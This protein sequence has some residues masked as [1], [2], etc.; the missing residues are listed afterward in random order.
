M[1]SRTVL[2]GVCA[3]EGI[4]EGQAFV[5]PDISRSLPH[6]IIPE[7]KTG[8]EIVR[9]H[10]AVDRSAVQIRVLMERLNDDNKEIFETHLMQL[11]DPLIIDETERIIRQEKVNAEH[12]FSKCTEAIRRRLLALEDPYFRERASDLEDVASRV[13]NNLLGRE[14]SDIRSIV[15]KDMPAESVVIAEEISPSLFLQLPPDVR[16]I[17][18]EKGGIT[19]HMAILS[20]ARGIPAVVGASGI[21][22]AVRNGDRL[23]VQASSGSVI[24]HPEPKDLQAAVKKKDSLSPV[25][26]SALK[27]KDGEIFRIWWNLSSAPPPGLPQHLAGAGLLRTEFL[28]MKDLELFTDPEKEWKQYREVFELFEQKSVTVRLLDLGEDKTILN[29]PGSLQNYVHEGARGIRLLL[30]ERTFLTRQLYAVL[31]AAQGVPC[32]VRIMLPMVAFLEDIIDFRTV[33]DEVKR[34]F[35]KE[36]GKAAKIAVGVMIETPAACVMSD[37]FS[38]YADFFSL[39]TNDLA[40]FSLAVERSEDLGDL[41]Y[42]PAVLRLVKKTAELSRVPVSICGEAASYPGICVILAGFGIRDFSM[43]PASVPLIEKALQQLTMKQMKELSEKALKCVDASS[44]RGL[45]FDHGYDTF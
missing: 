8:E 10:E 20:R 2:T 1:G 12:A 42:Q 45:L 30:K 11:Q 19:G 16:A 26:S 9:F 41:F 17:V 36:H 15:L 23:L 38:Q 44:L 22:S 39:G 5:I 21:I 27:S 18:T 13:L 6:S 3:S 31:R 37:V 34:K 35:E 43:N 29:F 4:V 7:E 25:L 32:Q 33:F 28:Y 24:I 14:G 40:R